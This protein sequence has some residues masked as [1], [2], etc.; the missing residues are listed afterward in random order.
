MK[1]RSSRILPKCSL[2][3]PATCLANS[4]FGTSRLQTSKF[5]QCCFCFLLGC[6]RM[7]LM[8]P[9]RA[10][11]S[12]DAYTNIHVYLSMYKK[13]Y[14]CIRVYIYLLYYPV[15]ISATLS[16]RMKHSITKICLSKKWYLPYSTSWKN[17]RYCD[18]IP[19]KAPR[20]MTCN[21]GN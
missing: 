14:I 7:V 3:V 13:K 15:I 19:N 2:D 17:F 5:R 16:K 4:S 6:K 9:N 1:Y 8:I 20:N 18:C 10:S 21:L 11:T 12:I